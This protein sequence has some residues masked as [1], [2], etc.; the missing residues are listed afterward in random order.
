MRQSKVADVLSGAKTVFL[1][2][3]FEGA[4]VDAIAEEAKVSKATLY[5]RSP[6]KNMLFLRVVQAECDRLSVEISRPLSRNDSPRAVLEQLSRRM[7][8]LVLDDDYIRLLRT[9]TRAVSVLPE[10]G[11]IYM[12]AGP[13]RATRIVGQVLR[14]LQEAGSVK[15]QDV[16]STA[17][18]FIH[19][20]ISG[21]IMPRLLAVGQPIDAP[22]HAERAVDVFL[23]IYSAGNT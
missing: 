14:V 15:M 20:S 16:Q 5:A 7:I 11:Q 18:Q 4:S 22:A 3:G 23:G 1:R 8:R 21:I 17:S 6:S 2:C 10:A 9:C 19:L 12:E 13:R